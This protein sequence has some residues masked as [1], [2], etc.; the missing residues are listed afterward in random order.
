MSDFVPVDEQN[1]RNAKDAERYRKLR[2]QAFG[3]EAAQWQLDEFDCAVDEGE[4]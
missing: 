3:G 1:E 4:A 2:L